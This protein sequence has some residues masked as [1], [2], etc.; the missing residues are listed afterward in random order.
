PESAEVNN[1]LRRAIRVRRAGVA[2]VTGVSATTQ[3]SPEQYRV[4]HDT[5]V[6]LRWTV[7]AGQPV[8]TTYTVVEHPV[9]VSGSQCDA[10]RDVTRVTVTPTAVT[11]LS[12]VLTQKTGL[13]CWGHG[14]Q[15]ESTFSV[16]STAPRGAP[17]DSARSGACV[18]TRGYESSAPLGPNQ[19]WLLACA[20]GGS[21]ADSVK[22]LGA[23]SSVDAGSS[24]DA[25]F[26][27]GQVYV[28]A[29]DEGSSLD[30]VQLSTRWGWSRYELPV[31]A[32]GRYKV[33]LSFVEPTWTQPG[34]RVF[35]L[36]AEGATVR[37]R[38]DILDEFPQGSGSVE[39]FVDVQDGNLTID[40]STIVDHPIVS[41]IYVSRVGAAS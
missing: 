17:A 10:G 11:S 27:G 22:L 16:V 7:P 12:V 6:T 40:A 2:P 37:D 41:A 20:D 33:A 15:N 8:G 24:T 19:Y 28:A 21:L 36:S 18:Q 1:I 4:N 13:T 35:G 26:T 34:Q 38:F 14:S 39:A 31:P 32:A 29:P 5:G 23:V 3:T 30:A 9:D 25:G